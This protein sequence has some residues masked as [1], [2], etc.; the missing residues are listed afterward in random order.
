[1]ALKALFEEV[2][3][4][5]FPNPPAS[6]EQIEEFEQRV[7]WR[8]DPDLRAFYLHCDGAAL[9]KPRPDADY[10]FLSLA[11]IRRAR[12]AIRGKDDDS[13]GPASMYTLCDLQ[14]GDYILMDVNRQNSGRYPL[15]DGWHEAWPV[16][17]YCKQLAGSFSEFL[18]AALRSGGSWFW[19]R[20][21]GG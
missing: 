14:D 5:H 7:G 3:R 1:M 4:H 13:R 17:E 18:E 10:R 12:V 9:F 15:F 20:H 16:P 19:L 11:E 2:S 6:V 8:L 21:Q